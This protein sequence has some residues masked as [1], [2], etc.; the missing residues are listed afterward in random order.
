MFIDQ[1]EIEVNSGKGGKGVVSF[2][3]EKYAPFGGPDGGD[4]GK[5]G[6]VWIRVNSALNTLLPLRN[7][8]RYRA[9]DGKRGGPSNMTGACGVDLNLFV[10]PGTLVRDRET[11]TLLADLTKAGQAF[12]VVAGG[13]G[14]K[15]NAHFS[16]STHQAPRFSQPG[17]PG[18]SRLLSLELKMMADVGLV[19]FPNAGKSTLVRCLS[20]ARPK[21]ANYPFTTLEPSLGVVAAGDFDG[22]VMA[23]IPGIIEGASTG[24]GLGMRFIRH[25]ERTGLLLFLIDPTDVERSVGDAYRTLAGELTCFNPRLA[26]KEHMVAFTKSDCPWLDEEA[27]MALENHLKA[28]GIRVFRLSALE[29]K[30]TGELVGALHEAVKRARAAAPALAEDESGDMPEEQDANPSED[31]LDELK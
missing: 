22:F 25:I 10:P 23:D 16:S 8:R 2:R 29:R 6:S 31:P 11:G 4:G 24:A 30:G 18:Q 5:G 21:V 9:E 7:L 13:R 17:E 3:R 20:A 19:G 27:V 26:G 1:M 12:E 14:G 28:E 15:G